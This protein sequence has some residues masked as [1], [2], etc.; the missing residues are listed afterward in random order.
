MTQAMH[1]HTETHTQTQQHRSLL[2]GLALLIG[3]AMALA[4]LVGM[5]GGKVHGWKPEVGLLIVISIPV[6]A[7]GTGLAMA[8]LVWRKE[9]KHIGQAALWLNGMIA[10]FGFPLLIYW[11]L[12]M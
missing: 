4:I 7:L 6:C 2:A 5:I 3:I 12:A 8:S 10:F 9:S 11:L 1:G